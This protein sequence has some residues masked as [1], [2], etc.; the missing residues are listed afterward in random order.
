TLLA[1]VSHDAAGRLDDE[2]HAGLLRQRSARAEGGDRA[3]DQ[4]RVLGV[5][6]L[7]AEA[8]PIHDARTEVLDQHVGAAHQAPHQRRAGLLAD[9]DGEAALVAVQALEVEPAD[10]RRKA[11]RSVGVADAV[12][13]PRLLDLD[14]VGAHVAEE[15][16][17]PG[18]RRLM[19]HVD[20]ADARERSPGGSF[21]HACRAVPSGAWRGQPYGTGARVPNG[22][23]SRR[24][25]LARTTAH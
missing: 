7:P 24:R 17:A 22:T 14:D 16:R 2:I 12:A 5:Q 6:R 25:A 3:V 9:V 4:P 1:G 23:S 21:V 10:L 11:A 19:A 18:P 8:V 20:D 13:A 15:R